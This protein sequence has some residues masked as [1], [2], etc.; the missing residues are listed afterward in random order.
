MKML[1]IG[2]TNKGRNCCPPCDYEAISKTIIKR[3]DKLNFIKY[4]NEI[5]YVID[6]TT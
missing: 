3:K 2:S 5:G 1:T 6:Y 4:T